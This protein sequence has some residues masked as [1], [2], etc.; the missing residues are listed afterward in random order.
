[1]SREIIF[2]EIDAERKKQEKKW[3]ND[4][5]DK[6]TG[7]DWIAYITSY[8]GKGLTYP[9]DGHRYRTRMVQVAALAVAAIENYDRLNGEIAKRHYDD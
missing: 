5:D 2:K 6:N 4:F 1:M 8:L 3:G 7:N 9:W